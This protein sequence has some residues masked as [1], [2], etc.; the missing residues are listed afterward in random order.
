VRVGYA[1]YPALETWVPVTMD[2]EYRL[3]KGALAVEGHATYANF[4]KFR[5]ET[6]INIKDRIPVP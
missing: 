4:R 3:G 6:N 2:E 5:V 1:A